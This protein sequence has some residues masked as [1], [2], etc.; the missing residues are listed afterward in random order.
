MVKCHDCAGDNGAVNTIP[1]GAFVFPSVKRVGRQ[2]KRKGTDDLCQM[3]TLMSHSEKCF[4][5]RRSQLI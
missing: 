2:E 1:K 4:V 5:R 3:I